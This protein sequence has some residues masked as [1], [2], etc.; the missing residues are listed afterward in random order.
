MKNIPYGA[1]AFWTMADKLGCGLQQLLAGARKFNLNDIARD[2]IISGNRETE[3]ETGIPYRTDIN[4]E[5]AIKILN[6]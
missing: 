5:S 2:D 3:R 4:N 6:S 1:I